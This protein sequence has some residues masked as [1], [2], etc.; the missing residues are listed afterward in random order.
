MKTIY[1]VRHGESEG[2]AAG[3]LVDAS[4]DAPLTTRGERQARQATVLLEGKQIDAIIASPMRRALQTAR[5][6]ADGLGY[7]KE[8]VADA[9]FTERDL[10]SATGL[11]REEGLA[12]VRSGKAVGFETEE[13][14]YDRAM[15]AIEKLRV[16]P[17]DHILVVGHNGMGKMMRLAIEGKPAS[18]F[19]VGERLE[20]AKVYEFIL[21]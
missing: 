14:L 13:Q 2:N 6:I 21:G 12:L 3:V 15:K 9:L 20:H 4:L 8:V 10:G 19:T 16:L 5:I 18:E 7:K 17:E 1:Y 11:P